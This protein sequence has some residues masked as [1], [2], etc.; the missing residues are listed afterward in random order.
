MISLLS[1]DFDPL[2]GRDRKK[3]FRNLPLIIDAGPSCPITN[4]I[5]PW[6]TR[7]TCPTLADN[8]ILDHKDVTVCATLYE[9]AINQRTRRNMGSS[10]VHLPR[11]TTV[12][13]HQMRLNI[14]LAI[15]SADEDRKL[16]IRRAA[17][18]YQLFEKALGKET[19]S[20]AT[21][22]PTTPA[23]ASSSRPPTRRA[24][25]SMKKDKGHPPLTRIPRKLTNTQLANILRNHA[26]YELGVLQQ[27]PHLKWT[28]GI[29]LT[30]LD[31]AEIVRSGDNNFRLPHSD[32]DISLPMGRLRGVD[33]SGPV[34]QIPPT[35][36][37][38]FSYVEESPITE[39]ASSEQ[40][41]HF[42]HYPLHRLR[43]ST[44]QGQ[45][46]IET[47]DDRKKEESGN[48][49]EVDKD[50][51]T[52]EESEMASGKDIPSKTGGIEVVS[53][54]GVASGIEVASGIGGDS[55][56]EVIGYLAGMID[57]DMSSSSGKTSPPV[58]REASP[59]AV[60]LATLGELVTL[61]GSDDSVASESDSMAA[62]LPALRD[63]SPPQTTLGD[64]VALVGIDDSVTS[65]SE[66]DDMSAP[67]LRDASPPL[68]TLGDLVALVG[69]DD[70][71]TSESE[72]DN[73][74][75]PLPAFTDTS[76]PHAT[77]G[78]LVALVGTDDSDSESSSGSESSSELSD[79]SEGEYDRLASLDILQRDNLDDT[80]LVFVGG[81][82][83]E[84]FR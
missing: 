29:D 43:S 8:V 39:L 42:H 71:V 49:D 50:S 23:V 82:T 69:S 15:S 77:L 70:S 81:Y 21:N 64:L 3:L 54:I 66:S 28:W 7:Q 48:G 6:W 1:K 13:G 67:A 61:V 26:S 27:E 30:P 5:K 25:E 45:L 46:P 22:P 74:A 78:D 84:Q 19:D 73:M 68:T 35:P 10:H 24:R 16:S 41:I 55:S 32:Y 51:S 37:D 18:F 76:L 11:S 53:G 52:P 59:P 34:D 4:H 79:A 12:A 57:D 17:G 20:I 2:P 72:S 60:V 75:S 80:P 14:L 62:P 9:E 58:I 31:I 47:N 38:Q 33:S 63:A 65:E 36:N 40:P 44:L 56:I 83:A